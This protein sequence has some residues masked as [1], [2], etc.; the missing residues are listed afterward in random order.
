MSRKAVE[1]QYIAVHHEKQG[2]SR[3]FYIFVSYVY[4]LC[5]QFY[6]N[7]V[8]GRRSLPSASVILCSWFYLLQ[9]VD[10]SRVCSFGTA[11]VPVHFPAVFLRHFSQ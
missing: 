2:N 6:V 9:N 3:R 1:T 10:F 5:K 4:V 7:L 8:N 11:I